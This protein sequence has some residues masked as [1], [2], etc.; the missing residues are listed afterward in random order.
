MIPLWLPKSKRRTTL[1]ERE[2]RVLVVLPEDA[3]L[4]AAEIRTRVHG[5]SR[6]T[7]SRL[8]QELRDRKLVADVGQHTPPKG[9]PVCLWSRTKGGTLALS[10]VSLVVLLFLQTARAEGPTTPP[11]PKPPQGKVIRLCDVD[12]CGVCCRKVLG[13]QICKPCCCNVK[14]VSD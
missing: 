1:S 3:R 5:E 9:D 12:A 7:I 2:T 8:L 13:L 4:T 10:R 11:P 14:K 6:S